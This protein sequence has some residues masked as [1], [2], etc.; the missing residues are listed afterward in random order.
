MSRPGKI[1]ESYTAILG[2]ISTSGT[3]IKMDNLADM[4]QVCLDSRAKKILFP[5]T[6]FTDFVTVLPEMMSVFQLIPYQS[7]EDMA[8]KALG[9]VIYGIYHKKR[10]RIILGSF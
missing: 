10:R 4:L 2:E 1:R 7:A 8:F 5:Q 9:G 6:F 3:L